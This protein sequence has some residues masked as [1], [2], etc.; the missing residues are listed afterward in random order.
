M[1]WLEKGELQAAKLESVLDVEQGKLKA[2]GT[3]IS[4]G[5]RFGSEFIWDFSHNFC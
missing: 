4:A 5:Q 2:M 1:E 3:V